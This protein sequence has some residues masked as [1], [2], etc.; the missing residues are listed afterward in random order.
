MSAA[1][2]SGMSYTEQK[3]DDVWAAIQQALTSESVI[4]AREARERIDREYLVNGRLLVTQSQFAELH[5][6]VNRQPLDLTATGSVAMLDSIPVVVV[7]DNGQP[8]DVGRNQVAFRHDAA[9]YVITR[10]DKVDQPARLSFFD[11][12]YP[13]L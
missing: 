11:R 8:V 9:I 1:H 7:P 12:R 10:Q 5:R 4:A 6:Q 13:P 2:H 3:P